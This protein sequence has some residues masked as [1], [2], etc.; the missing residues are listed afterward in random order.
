MATRYSILCD[1]LP[2]YLGTCYSNLRASVDMDTTMSLATD[3]APDSIGYTHNEGTFGLAVT[4][5]IQCV[6]SF[7]WE[8]RE[9]KYTTQPLY[10]TRTCTY[11][12]MHD[13]II[14]HS[15]LS[16]SVSHT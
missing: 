10:Y 8:H 4:H 14:I 15:K 1:S 3:G 5:R 6:C 7:T 12:H 13:G 2:A 9:L 11:G 16:I